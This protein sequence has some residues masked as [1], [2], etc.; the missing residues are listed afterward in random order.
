MNNSLPTNGLKYYTGGTNEKDVK[1]P[2]STAYGC[3]REYL[4]RE[5]TST[6]RSH[7]IKFDRAKLLEW[8]GELEE[9]AVYDSIRIYLGVYPDNGLPRDH[10]DWKDKLTVFLVP[11]QGIRHAF[12]KLKPLSS[13]GKASSIE[14][15]DPCEEADEICAYNMGEIY[16]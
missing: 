16:P 6:Q 10:Q 4:N 1:V 3:H 14:N 15:N 9:T 7:Y 12:R 5:P 13:E 8:F 2:A 11:Y